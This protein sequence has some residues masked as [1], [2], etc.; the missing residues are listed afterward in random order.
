MVPGIYLSKALII[1]R[2]GNRRVRAKTTAELKK[3][4]KAYERLKEDGKKKP[5][6]RQAMAKVM[7]L[8]AEYKY[9]D[10]EAI[11][12]RFPQSKLRKGL[13]AKAKLLGECE[14]LFLEVTKYKSWHVTAGAMYRIGESYYVYAKSLF[15]LPMPKG[16]SED[17][18]F[19]YRAML[20]DRASPLEEKAIKG[21]KNALKLAHRNHVYNEWS[22]K[23]AA[24]LAEKAP[25]LYPVIEDQVVNT[26]W[27]VPATFSTKF[28]ADPNG[29]LKQLVPPKPKPKPKKAGAKGEPG[30]EKPAGDTG[31]ESP[32]KAP[33]ADV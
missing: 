18:E 6:V 32:E 20:E 33:A 2:Q 29:T 3:A 12:L 11:E 17:E 14:N 13:V 31:G 1:Q 10:F 15:E 28:I 24:L 4:Q 27:T 19:T 30:T 8:Q 21:V 16:L 9:E 25:E 23:A 7:F 22:R 26:E 5:V